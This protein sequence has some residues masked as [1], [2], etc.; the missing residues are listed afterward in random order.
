MDIHLTNMAITPLGE[1]A[2]PRSM[3]PWLLLYLLPYLVFACFGDL[4]HA[5]SCPD[6]LLLRWIGQRTHAA[7]YGVPRG[8]TIALAEDDCVACFWAGHATAQPVSVA[9]VEPKIGIADIR[10]LDARESVRHA[11]IDTPRSRGPPPFLV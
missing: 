1:Q 2:R 6:R 8:T 4:M 7:R 5:P 10:F 11:Y 3:R 9:A